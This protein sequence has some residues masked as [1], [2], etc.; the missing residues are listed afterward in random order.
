MGLGW[1]MDNSATGTRYIY[2][3]GNTKIGYNT[4]LTLY[5][6]ERL[7]I[8]I[9]VNDTINQSK[10]GELENNLKRALDKQ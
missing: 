2:H 5:P 10:V 9:I 7:G 4:L 3:D 6:A 1:M 8:I